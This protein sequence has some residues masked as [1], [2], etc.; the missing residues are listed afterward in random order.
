MPHRAFTTYLLCLAGFLAIRPISTSAQTLLDKE[1]NVDG[2]TEYSRTWF[3]GMTRSGI[4]HF[5]PDSS[6]K[7]IIKTQY[8]GGKRIEYDT[9]SFFDD[10]SK[11]PIVDRAIEL[12]ALGF[13]RLFNSLAVRAS[14]KPGAP[15]QIVN[16]VREYNDSTTDEPGMH[17][18]GQL[19][20]KLPAQF[21]ENLIGIVNF[22]P[23]VHINFVT[24]IPGKARDT[25]YI[26]Y[27]SVIFE[28]RFL[29]AANY[30]TSFRLRDVHFRDTT[31]FSF[32]DNT[33][34]LVISFNANDGLDAY[35]IKYQGCVFDKATVI[36]ASSYRARHN[37]RDLIYNPLYRPVWLPSEKYRPT[38][39][40]D[41]AFADCRFNGPLLLG[42][43]TISHCLFRHCEFPIGLFIPFRV[44]DSCQFVNCSFRGVFDVRGMTPFHGTRLGAN[45]FVAGSSVLLT[46]DDRIDRLGL[47]FSTLERV[48]FVVDWGWADPNG[49]VFWNEKDRRFDQATVA[50]EF[51]YGQQ[52]KDPL[53]SFSEGDLIQVKAVLSKVDKYVRSNIKEDGIF[54]SD[55]QKIHNWLNYQSRQ[56]EKLYY[57]HQGGLTYYWYRFLEAS[58]NFGYKGEVPFVRI[59]FAMIFLFALGYRLFWAQP[60]LTYY[61]T[62][63]KGAELL[64]RRRPLSDWWW[65]RPFQQLFRTF[66]MTFLRCF[67]F[68]F[69]LF[70]SPKF[71]ST[72]FQLEKPLLRLV[73]IEWLI[74]LFFVLLFLY[75]IA[76]G[77]PVVTKLLGL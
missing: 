75:Y 3:L 24:D 40:R 8:L 66:D 38:I 29:F 13:D 61:S 63:D 76:S 77:Y 42:A 16:E 39:V 43:D 51:G 45:D 60:V 59:C 68:S 57:S 15:L 34:D 6:R 12:T 14:S 71:A 62:E 72:Y 33:R 70:F 9:L 56:Y 48:F 58:V 69:V 73:M 74:G 11:L 64:P 54:G 32:N 47:D 53:A 52:Y 22:S 25:G 37:Q 49:Y 10:T 28:K 21:M 31:L 44:L 30:F 19:S 35:K 1:M 2:T 46:P 50:S 23:N 67:Y 18:R 5:E 41:M 26:R 27:D 7:L 4:L 20:V 36:S 17:Y 65:K 55:K